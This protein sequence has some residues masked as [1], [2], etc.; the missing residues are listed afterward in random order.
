MSQ[1]QIL[2]IDHVGLT[3]PPVP[4]A[5]LARLGPRAAFNSFRQFVQVDVFVD[6]DHP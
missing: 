2:G 3:V 5:V 4:R 1:I 6:R